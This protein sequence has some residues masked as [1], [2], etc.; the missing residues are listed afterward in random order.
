MELFPSQPDLSLQI[1]L[2]TGAAAAAHGHGLNARFFAAAAGAGGHNPAMA[3][4]PPSSLQLPLPMP[5]PMAPAGAGGLQ[6]YPDAAA[7]AAAA[8]LRPIRGVPLYH[9]HQQQHAA[10]APFVGAAPL[11]HHPSSGGACYCEPC[12]VAGAW[13]RGGCGGGGARG[14]LPA[15]RAPRAPRMRW[16]S[17]LHARFV[18]AVELLGGHDRATPKSVLELMDVKDLTLAHVKSHLQMYRTV[19]NTERPAA[20]SDQADGFE[21][22]SA[23]EICDENSLDL[24]GGCRPEAMSAAARHGREDWSGFHESNTGTMQT[25]KDMQSKSLEIISDMNS[26]VSETTSS[27]SELNLEFT[28]GRPQNR[29]N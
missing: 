17:T 20:S 24:H 16:T 13:R 11:P 23:G 28:L 22:G 19:K 14:V 21:N 3:S 26:C 8:M 10:A 29:P 9:H 15:K 2:P 27:T 1:G 12:H 4:S 6:F 18:H 5:L 7:A 25:L